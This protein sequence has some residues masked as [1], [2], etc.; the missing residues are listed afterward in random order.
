M[1]WFRNPRTLQELRGCGKRQ[2][3]FR[4]V[5][6]NAPDPAASPPHACEVD[7]PPLRR[8]WRPTNWDDL[9]VASRADRSW[10]SYRSTQWRT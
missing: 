10:K 3:V 6:I 9:N 5:Q 8:R 2:R 1:G 4:V 7:E